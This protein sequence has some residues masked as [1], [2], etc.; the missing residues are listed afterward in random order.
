MQ[1]FRTDRNSAKVA[2]DVILLVR[3][4]PAQNEPCLVVVPQGRVVVPLRR[5][6]RS[7]PCATGP[8]LAPAARAVV[9]DRLVVVP[10]ALVVVPCV[11]AVVP[12]VAG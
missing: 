7:L 11:Y 9:P 1:D 6:Y 8:H 12:H 2:T 5:F 4:F 3:A 10:Q